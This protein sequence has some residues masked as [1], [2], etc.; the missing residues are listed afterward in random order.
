M[1]EEPLALPRPRPSPGVVWLVLSN[2]SFCS[3]AASFLRATVQL[4]Q[5][6]LAVALGIVILHG[7]LPYPAMALPMGR[8][9]SKT[10][11][12]ELLVG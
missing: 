8:G 2:K 1:H 4:L 10:L 6:L 7:L 5:L 3:Q 12:Q 9:K 11:F